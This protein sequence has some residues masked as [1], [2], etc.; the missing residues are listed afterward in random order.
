[1]RWNAIAAVLLVATIASLGLNVYQ[2]ASPR[3]VTVT[4]TNLGTATCVR[5]EGQENPLVTFEIQVNYSGPW[6]ALVTGYNPTSA[7]PP[8]VLSQCYVG[9]G[10]GYVLIQD[11][12]PN[13][14]A[15][16]NATVQK[17][18]ASHGNL[19]VTLAGI[20]RSTTTPYGSVTVFETAVP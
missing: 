9:N 14:Q 8:I 11:W 7:N 16:L 1:M 20:F 15:S 17:V 5:A 19:T 13:G 3:S 18:D 6:V 12:N 4:T 10:L 2:Y